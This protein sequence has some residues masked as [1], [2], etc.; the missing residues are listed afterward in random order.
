MLKSGEETEAYR[1]GRLREGTVC[2]CWR[3]MCALGGG[4][5]EYW[6]GY[7][8]VAE[9]RPAVS[10]L[11]WEGK[12]LP[13]MVARRLA[14]TQDTVPAISQHL[15]TGFSL[16]P[17]LGARAGV[18]GNLQLRGMDQSAV[19]AGEGPVGAQRPALSE[20]QCLL[21]K[22]PGHCPLF[23]KYA[24]AEDHKRGHVQE[25]QDIW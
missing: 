2:G 12:S 6:R 16:T 19:P 21:R 20:L 14:Q 11:R 25:N 8:G 24:Q 1:E 22:N 9:G 7:L 3:G 5:G 18:G 4:I 17:E 15:P 13:V 10:C 23:E